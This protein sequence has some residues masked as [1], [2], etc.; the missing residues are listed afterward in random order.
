MPR[1]LRPPHGV[2]AAVHRVKPSPPQAVLDRMVGH[3]ELAQ[4]RPGNHAVLPRR[5]RE[6]VCQG[7]LLRFP[8]YRP[9]NATELVLAP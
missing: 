4:L 6:H 3:A 1:E 8:V 5:Q 2:D 7:D 9:G